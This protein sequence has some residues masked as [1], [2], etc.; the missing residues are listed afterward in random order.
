MRDLIRAPEAILDLNAALAYLHQCSESAAVAL[1]D[2]VDRKCEQLRTV[3]FQ[4]RARD[5]LSP[6]LRSVLVGD[7]LLFYR[8]SDTEVQIVRFIHGRPDLPAAIAEVDG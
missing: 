3:P 6:G 1:A 8:V 4:G 2:A 5:D 7:H